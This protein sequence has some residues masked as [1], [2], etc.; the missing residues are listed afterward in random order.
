MKNTKKF[1]A[2]LSLFNVIKAARGIIVYGY[3]GI[4]VYGYRGIIVYG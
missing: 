4:I 2:T 1:T 3:K